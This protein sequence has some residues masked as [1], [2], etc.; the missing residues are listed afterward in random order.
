M[1]YYYKIAAATLSNYVI[2]IEQM[3]FR[4]V[5]SNIGKLMFE[6][7]NWVR[8]DVDMPEAVEAAEFMAFGLNQEW[9]VDDTRCNGDR[10]VTDECLKRIMESCQKSDRDIVGVIIT[11]INQSPY[12]D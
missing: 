2:Q 8:D 7:R 11:L 4:G 1:V 12:P 5:S 3:N 9:E 10:W 6:G